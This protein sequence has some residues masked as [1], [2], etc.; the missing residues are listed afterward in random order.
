MVILFIPL[1]KWVYLPHNAMEIFEFNRDYKVNEYDQ[2]KPPKVV[3]LPHNT[4][5]FFY[6]IR[7]LKVNEYNQLKPFH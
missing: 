5:E 3:Y 7:E 6:F 1:P 2:L 4:M